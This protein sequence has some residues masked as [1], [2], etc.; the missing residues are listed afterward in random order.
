MLRLSSTSA[1]NGLKALIQ[2]VSEICQL[3]IIAPSA[4][5]DCPTDLCYIKMQQRRLSCHI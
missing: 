2:E 3:I 4:L 1:F 5:G